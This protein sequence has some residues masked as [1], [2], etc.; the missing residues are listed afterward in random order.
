[1]NVLVPL[2]MVLAQE[3]IWINGKHIRA[4]GV[5]ADLRLTEDLLDK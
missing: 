3:Q 4:L 2:L 1:M 5:G